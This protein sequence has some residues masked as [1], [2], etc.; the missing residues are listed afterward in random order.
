M[1]KT[2][3]LIVLFVI[4]MGINLGVIFTVGYH[5]L[6]DKGTKEESCIKCGWQR[7]QMRQSLN[8]TAEQAGIMEK[9]REEMQSQILPLR[10]KLSQKRLELFRLVRDGKADSTKMDT[11]LDEFSHL[12]S[13]IEKK[14]IQHSNEVRKLLEPEQQKKF[15]D[16]FEQGLCPGEGHQMPCERS[17]EGR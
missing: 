8:L 13:E 7:R 1:I 14:V 15:F 11:L 9:Y 2:K 16:F 17:M 3:I 4:S 6:R 12:Q 10:E 5:W